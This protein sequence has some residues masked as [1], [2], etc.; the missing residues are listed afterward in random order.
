MLLGCLGFLPSQGCGAGRRRGSWIDDLHRLFL[1]DLEPIGAVNL[2]AFDSRR[3]GTKSQ[4]AAKD[5]TPEH[6][7]GV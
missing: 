5:T 3:E 2:I 4:S 7:G 1:D 6:G